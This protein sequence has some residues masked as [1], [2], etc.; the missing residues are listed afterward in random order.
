M[1]AVLEV[2]TKNTRSPVVRSK[3]G[4]VIDV[5]H[6]FARAIHDIKKTAQNLVNGPYAYRSAAFVQWK[7]EA[8]DLYAEFD[9]YGL[10]SVFEDRFF[11]RRFGRVREVLT[12]TQIFASFKADMNGTIQDLQRIIQLL[13]KQQASLNDTSTDFMAT[14]SN[15]FATFPNNKIRAGLIGVVA[16]ATIIAVGVFVIN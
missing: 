15:P 1:A 9:Q 8:T 3:L 7:K 4:R 11:Q 2:I 5:H 14:V 12:E 16:L 13:E 10:P 6:P